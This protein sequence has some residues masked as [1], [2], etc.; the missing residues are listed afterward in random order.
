LFIMRSSL[1]TQDSGS[2]WKKKIEEGSY[3]KET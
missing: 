3:A 2:I 1:M